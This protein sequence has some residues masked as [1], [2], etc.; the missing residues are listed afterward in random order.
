M[1]L[2]DEF[3]PVVPSEGSAEG[4]AGGQL[5]GGGPAAKRQGYGV[6]VDQLEAGGTCEV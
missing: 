3:V 6:H 5:G 1:S 4:F 2:L